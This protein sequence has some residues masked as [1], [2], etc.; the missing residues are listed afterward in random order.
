[1]RSRAGPVRGGR[2]SVRL[3]ADGRVGGRS[4]WSGTGEAPDG[5]RRKHRFGA[6]SSVS[7]LAAGRRWTTGERFS[8]FGPKWPTTDSRGAADLVPQGA[9]ANP[10]DVEVH[11]RE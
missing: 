5:D 6:G 9:V 4:R 8:A 10:S 1:M 3:P 7:V 2:R 11:T